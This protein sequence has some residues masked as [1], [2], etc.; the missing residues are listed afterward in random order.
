VVLVIALTSS[1]DDGGTAPPTN[2]SS[3]QVPSPQPE[4]G[5]K[6]DP[7]KPPPELPDSAVKHIREQLERIHQRLPEAN[8]L[9]DEGFVAQDAGRLKEAQEK[10][11]E[12]RDILQDMNEEANQVFE[13]Y[14]SPGFAGEERVTYWMERDP[15]YRRT[16]LWE[17][18]LARF[19]K[20]M[21]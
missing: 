8:K 12:A 11:R 4:T 17:D 20:H 5:P 9:I 16:A 10:W 3:L 21:D 15:V 7:E 19:I 18:A 1:G 14:A 13:M 6:P 2:Q